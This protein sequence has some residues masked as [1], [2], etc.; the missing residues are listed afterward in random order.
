MINKV[1]IR[2][3]IVFD[4]KWFS[5]YEKHEVMPSFF[6]KFLRKRVPRFLVDLNRIC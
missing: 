5:L 6:T 2:C 1:V 4:I 3:F